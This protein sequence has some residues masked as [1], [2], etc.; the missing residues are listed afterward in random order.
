MSSELD[1]LTVTAKSSLSEILSKFQESSKDLIVLDERTVITKPHLELL[2][3]YPR[4]TTAALVA[5]AKNGNTFGKI[6]EL[7]PVRLHIE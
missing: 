2:T 7:V 5:I 6:A 1:L 3:D 4:S